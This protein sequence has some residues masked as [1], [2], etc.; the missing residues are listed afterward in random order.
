MTLTYENN[1]VVISSEYFEEWVGI[2]PTPILKIE[3]SSTVN[4]CEKLFEGELE[5]SD[6]SNNT[7]CITPQFYNLEEYKD[8][9]YKYTLTIYYGTEDNIE[10]IVTDTDCLV[11]TQNNRCAIA[12]YIV[13][14]PESNIASLYSTLTLDHDCKCVCDKLCELF[15]YIMTTIS[16]TNESDCYSCRNK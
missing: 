15:N 6:I 4:C 9:V 3:L 13:D 5:Q 11:I 1:K 16:T 12:Q 8:G 7:L 10:S 14:N 2:S